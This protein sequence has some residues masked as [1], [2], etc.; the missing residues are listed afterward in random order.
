M[1]IHKGTF[2]I[3]NNVGPMYRS[4]GAA[5]IY[6]K[7]INYNNNYPMRDMMNYSYKSDQTV[8]IYKNKNPYAQL[9]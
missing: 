9:W 3:Y 5:M 2:G 6:N 4:E 1:Y 8:V 7:T